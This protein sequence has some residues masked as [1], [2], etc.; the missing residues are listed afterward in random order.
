MKR[1]HHR[2]YLAALHLLPC[3]RCGSR[4][5]IEA[6]HIR[7]TSAEWTAKT[8]VGTGAGG[9]EKPSDRWALPLCS[10]CHRTGRDAEHV[11]GTE[12]FYRDWGVDPH[13]IADELNKAFP[14]QSAMA[15]IAG[16]VLFFGYGRV[17]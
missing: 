5:E 9:A 8:G 13:F 12:R 10:E 16:R 17:T 4:H 11:V 6:A 1:Q 15:V 3:L 2:A 7:L 14:N